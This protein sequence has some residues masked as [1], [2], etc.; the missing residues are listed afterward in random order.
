M[1]EL[2]LQNTDSLDLSNFD[3]N[4]VKSKPNSNKNA[5]AIVKTLI[6]EMV[7]RE[8]ANIAN[9][10]TAGSSNKIVGNT[11]IAN[12]YTGGLRNA[13]AIA[14]T[15]LEVLGGAAAHK[16]IVQTYEG[17]TNRL[18]SN[19]YTGGAKNASAIMTTII[20][21]L[22]YLFEHKDK[23][24]LLTPDRKSF[25]GK[26]WASNKGVDNMFKVIANKIVKNGYSGEIPVISNSHESTSGK[27]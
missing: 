4:E 14:K 1:K 6:T 24:R 16:D 2:D 21:E 11:M 20:A 23:V 12:G 17:I 13:E 15:F 9:T 26:V 22:K 10:K 8:A 3:G 5:F 27:G 18:I 25:D 19:G 7:R